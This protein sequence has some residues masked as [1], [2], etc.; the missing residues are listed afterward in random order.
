MIKIGY[1]PGCSM[2]GTARE[3]DES[4]KAIAPHIGI[5]LIE[6]PDW[7]CCGATSAHNIN[8]E[9]SLA[10]PAR[11]LAIAEREG[12]DEILVPC[13]ACFNRLASTRDELNRKPDLKKR[14]S[15]TLEMEYK[16]TAYPV[17]ILDVIARISPEE[18]KNKVTNPL[19]FKTASYYGCLLVRPPEIVNSERYEDPLMMEEILSSLEAEPVDWAF[20]VECCGAGFS[21][22]QPDFV[23]KLSAKIIN[24]AEKC[25]A[26]A[27]IVAC[28]MCHANLDMRR[29]AIEKAA[30]RKY[31]IPVLYITQAIGMALGLGK[32]ELGIQR[33]SVKVNLKTEKREPAPVESEAGQQAEV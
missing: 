20:K 23:G 22:S 4:L 3:Y 6:I 19:R 16:G 15:E 7:N 14:I 31:N 13:A 30:G 18:I 10:L 11:I 5:E 21:I 2:P 27:I 8:H 12:M 24:N 32:K 1:Y 25:G 26:E 28:P 33:H 29:D 9:L 17:N